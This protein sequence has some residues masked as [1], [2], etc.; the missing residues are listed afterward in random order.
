MN[1]KPHALKVAHEQD[2]KVLRRRILKVLE[3]DGS[4]VISGRRTLREETLWRVAALVREL[5]DTK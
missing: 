1:K 4:C 2:R 3:Q 5:E